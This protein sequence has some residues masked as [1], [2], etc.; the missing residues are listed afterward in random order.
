MRVVRFSVKSYIFEKNW[1][2]PLWLKVDDEQSCG[3]LHWLR[4]GYVFLFSSFG[5]GSDDSIVITVQYKVCSKRSRTFAIT[6]LL[7]I[8]HFKHCPP[9]ISPLYWQCTAPIVSAIFGK[10]PGTDSGMAC[11]SLVALT[12]I[13]MIWK[14]HPFSMVLSLETE[15]SLLG[16]SPENAVDGAQRECGRLLDSCGLRAAREPLQCPGA[17]SKPGFSHNSDVLLCAASLK[18]ARIPW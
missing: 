2:I 10:P 13:S 14:W 4:Q 12:W 9:Q 3:T 1:A 8:V 11:R 15:G 5:N 7:L 18:C 6:S 16:L 17:T